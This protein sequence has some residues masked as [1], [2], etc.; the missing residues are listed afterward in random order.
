MTDVF[1]VEIS[2]NIQE[3]VEEAPSVRFHEVTQVIDEIQ[4]VPTLKKFHDE[5][6]TTGAFVDSEKIHLNGRGKLNYHQIMYI[7][8][9]L[10]VFHHFHWLSC[11][12]VLYTNYEYKVFLLTVDIF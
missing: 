6:K 8:C 5:I 9:L 11:G 3:L 4:E 10:Y 7:K 2:D 12:I 1:L